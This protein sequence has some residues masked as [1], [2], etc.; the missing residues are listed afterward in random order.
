M[1]RAIQ[2]PA[3]A[4]PERD[5]QL[6]TNGVLGMLLFVIAEAMMFGGLISAFTIAKAS[7]LAWP[8]P[9][10]PRLPVE[11]TAFN[12]L[13]L[14]VSGGFLLQAS[15]AYYA[16]RARR[17]ETVVSLDRGPSA[18]KTP[19]LLAILLGAFFVVF[20]G[21]EW[22]A[23]L[24]D[25]LTLQSSTHSSFFYLVVGMHGLH[26]VAALVLLWLAYGRLI[27]GRLTPS[28]IGSAQVLWYFVVGLWPVLYWRVYL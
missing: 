2:S 7:A 8:P 20:Q 9:G 24:S 16:E 26:A 4:P 5:P 18:A 27:R 1:E 28:V 23:L 22:V 11:A 21:A 12:S 17:L 25:G 6:L 15:R 3:I 14:L 10:Q 13:V 19:F